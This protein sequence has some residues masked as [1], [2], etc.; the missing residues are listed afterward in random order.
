MNR[1]RVLLFG[2]LVLASTLACRAATRLIHPDTPTPLLPTPAPPS[3]TPEAYC[4]DETAS[5]IDAAR[6]DYALYSDF[7]HVNTGNYV[8]LPL[9]TY[10]VNGDQISDPVMES[11]PRNLQP[12]Q[13]DLAKQQSGWDLFTRLIPAE[14][15]QIVSQYQIITDGAGDLLA[16]VE[17]TDDD[18]NRWALAL[19]I[20]DMPYTK[21]LT[22]T[23]LHEFGHLLTLSPAQVPPDMNV[24]NHPSSNRA[25]EQ[26]AAA[27]PNYFPGEGCSLP[28][29][30]V[31][32]FFERYWSNLYDEWQ[33]IDGIEN[34]S[35]RQDKLDVFYKTYQ[36]Q[37]LDSY[38]VT[39]PAEDLAESWAFFIVSPKP[40]S[41]TIADQKILFFYEYPELVQLRQQILRNLCAASP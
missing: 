24:F 7:P 20:A 18:P 14:Q 12:Y 21:S 11:V 23:L 15:R 3:A 22:F 38:A 34:D 29:S 19:D 16:A 1:P 36:D 25:Y 30:Y 40:E 37:F 5:I 31:N 35:R 33:T 8:D 6:Q 2:L 32:V 17:Q 39:D 9:V 27:C 41:D 26:A 13:S 4:P 10:T 28:N